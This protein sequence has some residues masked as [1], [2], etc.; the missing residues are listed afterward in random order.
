MEKYSFITIK[1]ILREP[2]WPT[3]VKMEYFFIYIYMH[4]HICFVLGEAAFY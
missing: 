2:C 4:T 1:T 3:K